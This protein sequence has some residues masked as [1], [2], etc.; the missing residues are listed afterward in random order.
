MY[1]SEQ[2]VHLPEGQIIP[3]MEGQACLQE[4]ECVK[5]GQ[6]PESLSSIILVQPV[7]LS[8]RHLPSQAS[9]KVSLPFTEKLQMKPNWL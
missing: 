4:M 2:V 5:E 9:K 8:V 6:R 7:T 1:H 3:S